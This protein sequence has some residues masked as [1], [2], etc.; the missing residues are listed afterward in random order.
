VHIS[1]QPK[2]NLLC[3]KTDDFDPK[4]FLGLG[5]ANA[6]GAISNY[7]NMIFLRGPRGFVVQGFAK[8]ELVCLV[9]APVN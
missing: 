3:L 6:S 5:V 7:A 1:R 4:H 2:N 9:T 8:S